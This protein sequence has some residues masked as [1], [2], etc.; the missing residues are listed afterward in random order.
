MA[1]ILLLFL[2][3]QLQITTQGIILAMLSGGIASGL[4]YTI[5]YSALRNL[6][7]TQAAVLQLLVPVIA[8]L[9]GVIFMAEVMTY[10]LALSGAMILGGILLVVLAKARLSRG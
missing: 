3:S 10:R 9:G 6:S 7:S 4:G 5:W 2:F 1:A 8:A